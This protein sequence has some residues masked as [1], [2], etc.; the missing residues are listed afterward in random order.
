[1]SNLSKIKTKLRTTG[2]VTGNFG[3]QKV[4]A[5][6]TE[7]LPGGGNF[8]THQQSLERY[9]KAWPALTQRERVTLLPTVRE[10]CVVLDCND[11]IPAVSS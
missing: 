7:V 11:L 3:K 9:L 8:P 10:L 6:T 5:G 2:Q 1:M 4:K